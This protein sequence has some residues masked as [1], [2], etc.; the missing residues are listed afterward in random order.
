MPGVK[1]DPQFRFVASLVS[2]AL[3]VRHSFS[4]GGT[5]DKFVSDSGSDSPVRPKGLLNSP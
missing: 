5:S 2:R 4:A 1:P 3:L